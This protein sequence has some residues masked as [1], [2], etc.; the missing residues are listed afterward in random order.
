MA[1]E[2]AFW[3]PARLRVV[4][5]CL[6]MANLAMSAAIL[7]ALHGPGGSGTLMDF[8]ALWAA[9]R[10]AALGEAS[11][12]YD[13][14]AITA[15]QSEA[16][17]RAYERE[18]AW[19]YPPF[20]QLG[21]VPFGLMPMLAAQALWTMLTLAAYLTVCWRVLPDWG[22][23]LA[24][25]APA[26]VVMLAVNGQTGFLLA[27]FAGLA[28][29]GFVRGMRGQGGLH[30][31]LLAMK[32]QVALFLPLPFLM[33]GPWLALAVAAGT[34]TA[35]VALATAVFGAGVWWGFLDGIGIGA[36]DLERP[37]ILSN[38]ATVR[39]A[40][41]IAGAGPDLA[42][43][44]QVSLA[45]VALTILIRWRGLPAEAL[46]ALAIYAGIAATPRVMDYDLTILVI[47][48]LF[49]A[50]RIMAAGGPGWEKAVMAVVLLLPL[51]DLLSGMPLNWMAAPVL[52]LTLLF[53]ERVRARSVAAQSGRATGPSAG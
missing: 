52:M 24:G 10:M 26:T 41:L 1:V 48:G 14:A 20:L 38:Q 39:A 13:V 12:A 11:A 47:G 42:W 29:A 53:G 7:W 25:L 22:A 21:L 15:V 19:L 43:V 32:P 8:S 51:G 40:L 50:R 2:G 9:G 37:D 31:G 45:L 28:M 5:A 30:L 49:Q 36:R 6:A 44:A 3:H 16:L 34:V 23:V 46:A 35:L 27:A 4:L 18:M 17:G 33:R